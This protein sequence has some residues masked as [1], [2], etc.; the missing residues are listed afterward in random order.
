MRTIKT[1]DNPIDAHIIKTKL[2]S[3]GIMCYITDE[4]TIGLNPMLNIA[5]GGVKLNVAA[6]DVAVA[7]QIIEESDNQPIADNQGTTISCPA[8]NST[9]ILNNINDQK[10]FKAILASLLSLLTM[11]YPIYTKK[12]YLCKDCNEV[13]RTS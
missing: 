1:F 6:E 11:S 5:L 9:H 13:F 7:L 10:G 3:E 12:S 4:N 8:C 2:E